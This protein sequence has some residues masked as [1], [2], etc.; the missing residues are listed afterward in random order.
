[1]SGG[2]W[3][4]L[5]YKLEERA[6]DAMSAIEAL[7]LLAAIEHEMDWGIAGDSCYECAKLRVIAALEQ[8]FDGRARDASAAIAIVRDWRNLEQVCP[9]DQEGIKSY[10]EK[11]RKG[12]G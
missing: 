1:M 9:K 3:E 12:G 10:L 6:E 7:K 11:E 8:F 4:Y 2:H 5:S